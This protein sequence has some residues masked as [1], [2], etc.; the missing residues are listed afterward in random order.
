M[1]YRDVTGYLMALRLFVKREDPYNT[2]ERKEAWSSGVRPGPREFYAGYLLDGK[3]VYYG[4]S[5]S[6]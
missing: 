4:L 5:N 3:R 2:L 1:L 6:I